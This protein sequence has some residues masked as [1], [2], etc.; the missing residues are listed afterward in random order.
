MMYVRLSIRNTFLVRNS[1]REVV[2]NIIG[3]SVSEPH[4]NGVAGAEMRNI[5][6]L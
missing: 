4:T 1:K 6:I 2:S 3:T 5:F